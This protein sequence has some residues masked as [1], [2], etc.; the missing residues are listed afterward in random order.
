MQN[1]WY[2]NIYLLNIRK[3]T[4]NNVSFLRDSIFDRKIDT[5][6]SKGKKKNNIKGVFEKLCFFVSLV[7]GNSKRFYKYSYDTFSHLFIHIYLS[8]ELEVRP[9]DQNYLF[10]QQFKQKITSFF[11]ENTDFFTDKSTYLR[12]FNISKRLVHCTEKV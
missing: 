4:F 8:N 6:F 7:C 1:L 10:K 2:S 12:S 3:N 11:N 5:S 9:F